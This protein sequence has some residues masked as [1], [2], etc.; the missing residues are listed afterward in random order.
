MA[1][2]KPANWWATLPGLLTAAAAVITA[3]TGLLLGLGQLGVFDGGRPAATASGQPSPNS[4]APPSGTSQPSGPAPASGPASGPGGASG[5]TVSLPAERKYRSAD[6]EYEILAASVRPDVAGKVAL[7][8]SVRCTNHGRYDLN[9]WDSTFRLNAG[10]ISL[11]PESGLNE[12]VGGDSSKSGD[13]R[14]A[15]PADT[16]D[17]VLRIKFA[18]GESTVQISISPP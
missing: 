14:F 4:T 1:D 3:V 6:V 5:W 13:V 18:Q 17:S 11:S 2:E 9:F 10:G 7:T 8:F 16:R 12:L 15:V